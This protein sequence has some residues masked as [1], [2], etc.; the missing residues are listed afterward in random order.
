MVAL[1]DDR[2]AIKRGVE[3]SVAAAVEAVAASRLS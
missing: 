2:D 1:L 3:L